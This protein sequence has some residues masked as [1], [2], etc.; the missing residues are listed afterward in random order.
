MTHPYLRSGRTDILAHRGASHDVPPGNCA[1]AF[2]RALEAGVDHLETD[3]Q[4][5]SDGVVVLYHDDDLAISTTGSGPV[6]EHTWVEVERL[7]LTDGDEPTEN[8]L[9]RLDQALTTFPDAFWNIDVKTDDTVDPALE[10][11]RRHGDPERTCV[12]AFGARRLRRLRSEL[13]P[14]WCSAVAQAELAAMRVAAWARVPVPR[15]G[16]VVQ[17]PLR[18]RGI[19]VI[20]EPFVEACH[21]RDVAVHVWTVNDQEEMADLRDW[22]VDAVITDRPAEAIAAAST[23][24][25]STLHD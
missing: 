10:L 13:G 8:G 14:D 5:T 9:L 18:H 17:G 4:A 21:R 2:E 12:A 6:S 19:P 16:D 1:A 22:G 25:G 24:H 11:L 3:V 20:D 15:F 23:P 7:R